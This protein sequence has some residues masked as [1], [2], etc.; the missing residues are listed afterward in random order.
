MQRYKLPRFVL[1][2]ARK[3]HLLD[4]IK[5][6]KGLELILEVDE[7]RK[8]WAAR[9][10]ERMGEI[11]HVYDLIPYIS[12]RCE[13]RDAN[14]LIQSGTRGYAEIRSMVK[15][16]E[17]AADFT[18]PKPKVS[19]KRNEDLWN[20]RNIGAP[21]AWKYSLVERRKSLGSI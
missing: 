16:V 10:I 7:S 13:N 4:T 17:A 5:S 14:G 9:Q 12:L 3:K 21:E 11:I 15:S 20:L 6:R 8:D 2:Q 19:R 1:A 18:I